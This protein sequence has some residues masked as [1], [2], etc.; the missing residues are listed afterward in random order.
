VTPDA[1]H[2]DPARRRACVKRLAEFNQPCD[3]A[4][5]RDYAATAV[6]AAELSEPYHRLAERRAHGHTDPDRTS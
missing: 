2:I 4:R 1:V 3:R 6:R 5:M